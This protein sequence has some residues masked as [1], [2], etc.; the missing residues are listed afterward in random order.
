MLS[1]RE[2][3]ELAT[4]Y[5]ERALPLMDRIHF[6]MHLS[7]CRHCRRYVKQLR[8]TIDAT[9]RVP[10]PVPKPSPATQD[11]LLRAFRKWKK[12]HGGPPTS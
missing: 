2:M 3:T 11:A 12:G 6:L 9:G 4:A 7:M 8:L 10:L 5:A 1:C